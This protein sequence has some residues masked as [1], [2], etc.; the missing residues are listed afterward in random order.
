MKKLLSIIAVALFIN[1]TVAK[2][3]STTTTTTTPANKETVATDAA[4]QCHALT[5]T[6]QKSCTDGK[7]QATGTSTTL[8]ENYVNAGSAPVAEKKEVKAACSSDQSKSCCKSNSKA[9]SFT[10]NMKPAKTTQAIAPK[11]AATPE[12]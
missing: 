8:S 7:V 9:S 2:A 1:F 10:K 4:K 3:Q 12:Q 11:E 5:P 6:C